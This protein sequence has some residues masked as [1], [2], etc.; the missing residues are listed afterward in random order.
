MR[1]STKRITLALT[2]ALGFAALMLYWGPSG[3]LSALSFVPLALFSFWTGNAVYRL[4]CSS[5]LNQVEIVLP[6]GE[7]LIGRTAKNFLIRD[8][9]WTWFI[10]RGHLPFGY[11]AIVTTRRIMIY[12]ESRWYN[13]IWL[14][15]LIAVEW[16]A[17]HAFEWAADRSVNF[18]FLEG[19]RE[20]SIIF[21]TWGSY[22]LLRELL[23][24][25]GKTVDE[26]QKQQPS[27]M[28]A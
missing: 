19:G 25:V 5:D 14:K 9:S 13:E 4:L 8:S 16:T 10:T 1:Q 7:D 24:K 3:R 11:S 18:R 27:P 2:A 12:W 15:D 20:R 21:S 22:D 17:E 26:P 28:D 6:S 23:L